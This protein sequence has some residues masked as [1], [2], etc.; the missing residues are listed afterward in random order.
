MKNFK[1]AKAENIS[2]D[3][4]WFKKLDEAKSVK[5]EPRPMK[6]GLSSSDE[7]KIQKEMIPMFIASQKELEP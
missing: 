1:F 7:I 5:E 4:D 2:K 3:T 6:I